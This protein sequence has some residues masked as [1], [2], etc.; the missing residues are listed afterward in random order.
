[1]KVMVTFI[2]QKTIESDTKEKYL[3]KRDNYLAHLED[4]MDNADIES[5]EP[6]D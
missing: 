2:C 4:I 3:K 6:A 1:M 5:E